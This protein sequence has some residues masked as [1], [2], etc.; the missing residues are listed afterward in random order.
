[1]AVR[2]TASLLLWLICSFIST[3]EGKREDDFP[4]ALHPLSVKNPVEVGY[5]GISRSGDQTPMQEKLCFAD[6]R[7]VYPT[8]HWW[9]PAV[10]PP[11]S[12]GKNLLVQLPYIYNLLGTGM[13]V[14]YPYVKGMGNIVQNML[15][16]FGGAWTV[17]VGGAEGYCVKDSDEMTAT[18]DWGGLMSSTIV[19]GSPYVTAQYTGGSVQLTAG[20]GISSL[21]VDGA[22]AECSGAVQGSVFTALLGGDQ[23]WMIFTPPDT[24]LSCSSGGLSTPD[25]FTGTIRLALSNNCTTGKGSGPA[26]YCGPGAKAEEEGKKTW[27]D[28]LTKGSATCTHGSDLNVEDTEWGIKTT[29]MWRNTPCWP[30]GQDGTMMMAA[31]PHHLPVLK[32]AEV[33]AGGGHR[34]CRGHMKGVLTSGNEWVLVHP[35]QQV[36]WVGSPSHDKVSAIKK[37]LK[38]MGADSDM[39]YNLNQWAA[40][41]KIDP[42]NGGKLIA[43]IASLVLIADNL[44]EKQIA[45]TLLGRVKTH[46]SMWL[47]TRSANRLVYDKTW[48]GVISCGCTYI[49]DDVKKYAYCQ[50]DGSK[51]DCPTLTDPGYDFGNSIYNDHHFHYGYFIYS[52]GVVAKF[53]TK[54]ASKYNEKV[55]ALV[56]D[57]ANPS[58][59]DPYFTPFRMFDWYVGHSWALGIVADANGRNQESSSEAVNA[60][61][62]MYLYGTAMKNKHLKTLGNALLLGEA[63]ST[64]FYW[65]V[66]KSNHIYPPEYEHNIVGIM[67]EML[68]EFQ[69]FFGLRSFFVHGIQLIPITPMVSIMFEPE[70]VHTAYPNFKEGCEADEEC[71]ESGFVTFL[72]AEQALID[73]EGAWTN[74]LRLPKHVFTD[75][76]P[77]GNGNSR[78]A[79]LHFIASYGNAH[80]KQKASLRSVVVETSEDKDAAPKAGHRS[81]DVAIVVA[82]CLAVIVALSGTLNAV[83]IA[84]FNREEK[85]GLLNVDST[86]LSTAQPKPSSSGYGTGV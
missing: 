37:T 63:H 9:V 28:A 5:A 15:S 35:H 36:D 77:G 48:G 3:A 22:D 56:R 53:D 74:A 71:V 73:K 50:N 76:C 49:W 60:W 61:Y 58:R 75:E 34:N 29:I 38:G 1:M 79:L 69:T 14:Y 2:L 17:G 33:V 67:H 65:H 43:K 72:Y 62:G 51:L 21:K 39:N 32:S 64:N 42:Y 57:I 86:E 20:Q 12:I 41:G 78:T 80:A 46:L 44:G 59:R 83:M 16:E 45:Q 84:L 11:S 47:E 13:E 18:F 19:R 40:A 85:T 30:G 31:L 82:V 68:V 6:K 66:K 4:S 52:A 26:D 24:V 25:A 23:T 55:L 81:F 7:K 8:N 10:R 54:W 70:W 27:A